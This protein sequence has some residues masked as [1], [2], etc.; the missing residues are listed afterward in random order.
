[1]AQPMYVVEYLGAFEI[2]AGTSYTSASILATF[3]TA[4][5]IQ[6]RTDGVKVSINGGV[7]FSTTFGESSFLSTG[8]TYMFDKD[9]I[10][11]VG[12]Y[13]AIT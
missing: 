3:P 8:K 13:R 2:K 11:V 5:A 6:M 9:C 7:K 1:M 10:A 12:I 4:N